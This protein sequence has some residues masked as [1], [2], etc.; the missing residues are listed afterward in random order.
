VALDLTI[1]EFADSAKSANSLPL[2]SGQKLLERIRELETQ[3]KVALVTRVRLTT[4]DSQPALLQIGEQASVMTSR[5]MVGGRPLRE[6]GGF[7]PASASFVRQ[8]VGLLIGATPRVQSDGSL[9]VDL[10]LEK[11]QIAARSPRDGGEGAPPGV[12]TMKTQTTVHIPAGQTVIVG[13]TQ[14]ASPSESGQTLVLVSAQISPGAPATD[15]T[16]ATTAPSHEQPATKIFHL[17]HASA[18]TAAKAIH[19]LY[20]STTTLICSPDERTNSVI[21]RGLPK[22][23]AEVEAV[24]ERLDRAGK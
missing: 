13:G 5:R 23:L 12:T 7:E 6:G 9:A 24:L 14:M 20:R 17:Q 16:S 8:H 19:T 2:E 1:A 21:A 3:G 11:S 15:R 18:A 22:D 10:D 4:L